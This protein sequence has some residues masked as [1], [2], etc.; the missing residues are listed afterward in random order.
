MEEMEKT[1]GKQKNIA[2]RELLQGSSKS[3]DSERTLR[4]RR[5]ARIQWIFLPLM[6]EE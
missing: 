1:V 5:S 6:K 4:A 2:Q 3:R